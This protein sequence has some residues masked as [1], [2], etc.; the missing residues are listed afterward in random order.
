MWLQDRVE[1]INRHSNVF[2]ASKQKFEREI[3]I[4]STAKRHV[5]PL[6]LR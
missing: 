2:G 6:R 3:D 1:E 4:R 5:A